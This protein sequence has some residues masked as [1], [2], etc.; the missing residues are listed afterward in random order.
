MKPQLVK[1]YVSDN[2]KINFLDKK[3]PCQFICAIWPQMVE[4]SCGITFFSKFARVK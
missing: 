4:D 1:K 3:I 2:I